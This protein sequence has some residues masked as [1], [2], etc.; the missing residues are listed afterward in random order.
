MPTACA[1]VGH[2]TAGGAIF[3]LSSDFRFMSTGRKFI[4]FNEVKIGVPVPYPADLFLVWHFAVDP[5]DLVKITSEK[6]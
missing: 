6:N 3:A 2:A 5:L 4:G 1:I